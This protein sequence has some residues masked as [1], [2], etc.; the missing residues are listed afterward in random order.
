M[1]YTNGHIFAV[2]GSTVNISCTYSYPQ[3]PKVTDKFW[4]LKESFPNFENL[5]SDPQYSGRV[6]NICDDEINRCTLIIRNLTESD[7]TVYMFRFTTDKE[8][9]KYFGQPGVTLSVSGNVS[10]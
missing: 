7:S 2:K 1:K 6:E 10:S 9:G 3:N 8:A 5:K 4:F